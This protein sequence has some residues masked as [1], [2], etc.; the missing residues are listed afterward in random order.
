MLTIRK[1][2]N[3]GKHFDKFHLSIIFQITENIFH[4]QFR[5]TI[6]EFSMINIFEK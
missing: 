4:L 1:K 2:Q 6:L 3:R 5:S